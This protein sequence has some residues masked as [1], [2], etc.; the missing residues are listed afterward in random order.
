MSYDFI[1]ITVH[2]HIFLVIVAISKFLFLVRYQPPLPADQVKVAAEFE[3]DGGI[4]IL[5]FLFYVYHIY[6][7]YSCLIQCYIYSQRDHQLQGAGVVVEGEEEG[8][9]LDPHQ[10]SF[11]FILNFSFV[12][13]Y[14]F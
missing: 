7:L 10:V 6:Y 11:F 5:L 3:Y 9:G 14:K 2:H 12:I 1:I 13:F 8:G 4:V